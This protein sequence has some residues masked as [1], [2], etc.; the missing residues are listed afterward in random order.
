MALRRVLVT[1]LIAVALSGC[2]TIPHPGATESAAGSAATSAREGGTGEMTAT[3][4]SSESEG[5]CVGSTGRVCAMRTVELSGTLGVAAMPVTLKT[6]NGP[7]KVE[8]GA[9]GQ[10]SLTAVLKAHGDTAEEARRHLAGV[11]FSWSHE[12]RGAHHL[13]AEA[14]RTTR[15]TS[16]GEGASLKLVVPA[17][18]L[19]DLSMATTNGAVEAQGVRTDGLVARSTNGPVD[20]RADV[21]SVHLETTNG[22]LSADLRPVGSGRVIAETTNGRIDLRLP[23]TARQGYDVSARTTN[24]VVD[25]RMQDGES[26][27]SGTTSKSFRTSGFDEREW[28]TSVTTKST[29]GA[30]TVLGR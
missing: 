15:G 23:E 13:A 30:V 3:E 17:S 5:P 2:M 20:I 29:N 1:L 26:S 14:K 28:R 27:S 19:M 9:E 4:R 6:F 25:I 18:L 12:E 16:H 11:S 24:G 7:V 10:W 21:T 22:A 8:T